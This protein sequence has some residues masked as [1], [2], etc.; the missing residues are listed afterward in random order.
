MGS[1]REGHV[2]QLRHRRLSA[3]QLAVLY[4]PFD[5]SHCPVRDRMGVQRVILVGTRVFFIALH[6]NNLAALTSRFR[7]QRVRVRFS[8]YLNNLVEP[9]H[10]RVKQYRLSGTFI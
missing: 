1:S 10:W 8:Q 4:C 2:P 7:P 5:L 6:R 9:D 3:T